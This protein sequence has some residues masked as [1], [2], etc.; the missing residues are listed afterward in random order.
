[1]AQKKFETV[2]QT[3]NKIKEGTELEVSIILLKPDGVF[4]ARDKRYGTIYHCSPVILYDPNF[5]NM[6]YKKFYQ[7]GTFKIK[8]LMQDNHSWTNLMVEVIE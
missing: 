3:S 6:M 8:V 7:T 2:V 1:M 5:Y 4:D